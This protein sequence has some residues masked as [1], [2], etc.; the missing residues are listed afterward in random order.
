MSTRHFCDRCGLDIPGFDFATLRRGVGPA[1]VV[2]SIFMDTPPK[3]DLGMIPDARGGYSHT[4]HAL[5]DLCASCDTALRAWLKEKPAF[6]KYDPRWG[7]PGT[8]WLDR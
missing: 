3:G 5:F 2:V 6:V 1:P 7:P 8:G 4:K